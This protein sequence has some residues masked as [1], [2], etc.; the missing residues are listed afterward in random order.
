MV[1]QSPAVTTVID[2]TNDT[3]TLE[4]AP[5]HV[6]AWHPITKIVERKDK[7]PY[8]AQ[9]Q[10]GDPDDIRTRYSQKWDKTILID[11]TD[12]ARER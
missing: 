11:P 6:G 9:F 4:V 8:W 12:R 2:K 5:Y 10:P 3:A 7:P 1:D